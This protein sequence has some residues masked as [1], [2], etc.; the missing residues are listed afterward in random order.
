MQR[1]TLYFV[2]EWRYNRWGNN[3]ALKCRNYSSITSLCK[4]ESAKREALN[5][6]N[7]YFN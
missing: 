7:D 6:E 5:I 4:M 1:T 2:T 3:V